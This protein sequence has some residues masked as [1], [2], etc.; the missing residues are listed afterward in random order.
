MATTVI[1]PTQSITTPTPSD[2][3]SKSKASIDSLTNE[4]TFLQL[5]VAQIKNQ[6]P[7]NPTDGVQ[8]LT[9]LTGFSQL[10]QLMQINQE[11]APQSSSGTAASSNSTSNTN[12]AS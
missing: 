11:L 8:F 1:N 9:Q 3:Q 5:L 6:D 12:P 7:L 10:E 2:S 4:N